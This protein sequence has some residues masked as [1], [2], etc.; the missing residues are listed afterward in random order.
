MTRPTAYLQ[1]MQSGLAAD[2]L[3]QSLRDACIWIPF[4]TFVEGTGDLIVIRNTLGGMHR[5]PLYS[6]S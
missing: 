2:E 6:Q 5:H 1:D 4:V 3:S